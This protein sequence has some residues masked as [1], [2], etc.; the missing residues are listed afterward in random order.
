MGTSDFAVPSL[1]ILVNSTEHEVCLV[2]T[3]PDAPKGRGRR[4]S[5]PPVKVAAEM[6]EIPT[7]QPEKIG[8]VDFRKK[9]RSCDPDIIYVAAYGKFLTPKLLNLAPHGA[10][11]LHP[12]KLPLYRGA[13]P[14]QRTLIDGCDNTAITFTRVAR[15]M[16]A[17]D[18]LYQEEIMIM[19]D[20]TAGELLS[21]TAALGAERL[22]GLLKKIENSEIEPIPQDHDSATCAP[23]IKKTER[24]IDWRKNAKDIY[25]QWRGLAPEPGTCTFLEGKRIA[26]CRM[27]YP[28]DLSADDEKAG[29]IAVEKSRLFVTCGDG[30]TV[31]IT[32]I[33]TAGKNICTARAFI[34]GY[35]PHGK[36]F[37]SR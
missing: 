21:R 17:G 13:A 28:A 16:D 5:P 32:E 14:V 18:I 6:L 36:I 9:L 7:I 4:L 27:K 15:E 3:R 2:V 1:K 30:E 23:P 31:E 12:S 10:V 24:F 33:Q 37:T 29:L 25:N 34:N 26:I 22:P 11:N 20:E 35:R 8:T 19:P